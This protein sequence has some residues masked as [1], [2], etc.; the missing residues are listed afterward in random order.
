MLAVSA[1]HPF[2]RRASVSLDDL[3]RDEILAAP[4]QLPE[5]LRLAMVPERTPSGEPI[6]IGPP[7]ATIQEMLSLIGAG[8]GMYPVPAHMRTYNARPD[9]AYIAIADAPPLEWA[10]AWRPST[11]T[12]RIRVFNQT[13]VD[14]IETASGGDA[15]RVGFD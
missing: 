12:E 14:V 8:R 5:Y 9:V 11:E 15:V 10:L 1:R 13:A 2:A 4:K 6:R 7:F 3:A